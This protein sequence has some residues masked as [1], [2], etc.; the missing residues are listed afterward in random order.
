MLS[1]P[2]IPRPSL[3]TPTSADS[4]GPGSASVI[5]ITVENVPVVPFQCFAS[6]VQTAFVAFGVVCSRRS[7]FTNKPV[8]ISTGHAVPHMP[9]TA[10]VCTAWYSYSFSSRAARAWSPASSALRISRCR[11]IRCRGV[12]VRS[13]DGQ[14]G[15]Q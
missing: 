1:W 14:T 15:S 7:F 13:R 12:R 9:S 6:V 5:P 3:F 2:S 8:L 4:S 10:Q 11:A